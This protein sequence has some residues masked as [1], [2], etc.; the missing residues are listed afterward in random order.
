[1]GVE[2]RMW[3]H[4][5]LLLL[6]LLL[7]LLPSPSPSPVLTGTCEEFT[8]AACELSEN[9]IVGQNRF[10]NSPGECQVL[11]KAE[12][13]CTWFTHFASQCYLLL[14]CGHSDVC[15]GCVSGPTTPA[16]DT[17]PWPP[18]PTTP[19]TT[20]TTTTPK[21]TI[22]TTTP[23]TTTPTTTTSTTTTTTKTTTTV[24]TTTT[25]NKDGCDDMHINSQ[26]DWNYGLITWYEKVMTGSE[27]QHLCKNVR[28][29]EYFSHYNEGHHA[30]H[31]FC[32]CFSTCAWPSTSKCHDS[33]DTHEVFS[34]ELLGEGLDA[35]SE[36]DSSEL[37][38][39]EVDI[40]PKEFRH[41]PRWCHCIRG[42]LVP[43]VDTCDLWP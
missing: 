29:S 2:V 31:G 33:C 36:L 12:P 32:G 14:I 10:T 1:M 4:L 16:F 35:G 27:C 30:D 13:R 42:P 5:P 21:T 39:G 38:G 17:C 18:A 28:G 6:S 43:D 40:P 11:C 22:R 7:L 19:T 3:I 15:H 9:N 41:E 24:P 26:C 34:E 37:F 23:T 25:N 20:S 8:E